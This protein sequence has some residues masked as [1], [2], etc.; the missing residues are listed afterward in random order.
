M[1]RIGH[2]MVFSAFFPDYV[3]I[4][5]VLLQKRTKPATRGKEG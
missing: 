3:G 2:G 4:L 1:G 5:H